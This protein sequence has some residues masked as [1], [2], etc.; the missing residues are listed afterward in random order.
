MKLLR[1]L[2]GTVLL[3]WGAIHGPAAAGRAVDATELEQLRRE[4]RT[5]SHRLGVLEDV[6]AIQTL[7]YTYAY[8]VDNALYDEALTLF[9]DRI[10]SCEIGG[11]GVFTG[12]AGCERLWKGLMGGYYGGASNMMAFGE[13]HQHY[14]V[15]PIITVATDRLTAV[16]Q[17]DYFSF[18][19]RFRQPESAGH[20]IGMYTLDFGKE[21]GI[22]KIIRF[23]VTFK[24]TG[25]GRPGWAS[26]PPFRCASTEY[27]P[28]QP[29]TFY[30][31]FPETA[32]IPLR[33]LNPVT[34]KP[35][36]AYVNPQRYWFGYWP[37]EFGRGCGPR[38]GQ[39]AGD[40]GD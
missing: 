5:V 6:Q 9:S 33:H 17:F 36:P 7:A 19:G 8:L 18:G 1:V 24:T 26:R 35:I 11:Y 29:T 39:P 15:K 34:G 20:Q 22:W 23:W 25:F 14:M 40:A 2:A 31:P 32:V 10:V 21:D 16:G 28:D 30:H 4:L 13:L 38:A 37:G 27:P 3:S 12:K